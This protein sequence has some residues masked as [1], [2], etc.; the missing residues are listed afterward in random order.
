MALTATAATITVSVP[1]FRKALIQLA[2]G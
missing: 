2:L 1:F